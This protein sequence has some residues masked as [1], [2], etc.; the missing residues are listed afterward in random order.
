MLFVG[1]RLMATEKG[2]LLLL[3]LRKISSSSFFSGKY[4]CG[5]FFLLSEVIAS[6]SF[7]LRMLVFGF[8]FW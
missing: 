2:L 1:F 7:L 3:L 5:V 8:L 4:Y 6:C